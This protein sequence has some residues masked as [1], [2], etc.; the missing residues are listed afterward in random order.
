MNPNSFTLANFYTTNSQFDGRSQCL[1][2]LGTNMCVCVQNLCTR[3][4]YGNLCLSMLILLVIDPQFS[5]ISN[6]VNMFS[7]YEDLLSIIIGKF[8]VFIIKM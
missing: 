6:S 5:G 4:K 8:I 1:I 3:T 7:L 2:L